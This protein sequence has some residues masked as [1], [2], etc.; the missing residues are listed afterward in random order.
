MPVY[1]LM[2]ME[3]GHAG[4]LFYMEAYA[5]LQELNTRTLYVTE[6]DDLSSSYTGSSIGFDQNDMLLIHDKY[7]SIFSTCILVSPDRYLL[8]R[9]DLLWPALGDYDETTSIAMDV[10]NDEV[11][12][13]SSQPYG[14]F[15]LES[16]KISDLPFLPIAA[17]WNPNI[18]RFIVIDQFDDLYSVV[19]Y[20]TPTLLA[21]VSS[22]Y[23]STAT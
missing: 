10:E 2:L 7:I 14:I 3:V 12:V 13:F 22:M 6:Y 19:D 20:A 1:W 17:T 16:T 23:D 5:R 11:V 15:H 21:T 18:D 4:S 8:C 9:D